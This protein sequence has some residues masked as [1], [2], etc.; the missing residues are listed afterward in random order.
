MGRILFPK[1]KQSVLLVSLLNSGITTL[2]ELA[3]ICGV[4]ERTIRDWRREKFTISEEAFTKIQ[5]RFSLPSIPHTLLYDYWYAE[6][7][8]RQGGLRRLAL[9]G[10]PGT[11]EGRQKGG[12]MSQLMRKQFPERY[13]NCSIPKHYVTPPLS[14]KLAECIGIIL[15]DGGITPYQVKITLNSQEEYAYRLFVAKLLHKLFHVCPVVYQRKN[16]K[17]CNVTLAGVELIKILGELGVRQGSKVRRQAEVPGWILNNKG[18]A[19]ACLRGLMD[20]D[21]CIYHHNHVSHGVRCYNLGLT[22]TNL[23]QPLVAFVYQTL[24]SLGLTA[25]RTAR[26]VFVYRKQDVDRYFCT[27]SSHNAHHVQ[28]YRNFATIKATRRDTQVA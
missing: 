19:H 9:Y 21:G 16:E 26:G 25:K 13:P 17:A 24:C 2:G 10:P 22:F 5:Q 4:S 14:S 20:T 11:K 1:G 8:A 7:G 3:S 27:I 23:S 6:K 28:R 12:R 18:Y 15:G